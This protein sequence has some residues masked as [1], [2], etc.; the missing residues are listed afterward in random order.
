MSFSEPSDRLGGPKYFYD[1]T[2]DPLEQNNLYDAG[3]PRVIGWWELLLP[4]VD[5]LASQEDEAQP[6]NPGP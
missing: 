1:L 2:V 5:R 4:E 3:D 6:V